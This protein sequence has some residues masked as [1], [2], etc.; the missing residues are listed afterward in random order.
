M[1]SEEGSLE[2]EGPSG[3][4]KVGSGSR[5]EIESKNMTPETLTQELRRFFGENLK[6]VVLYGSAARGEY[7]PRY[8]DYNLLVL[9]DHFDLPSFKKT[10]KVIRAWTKAGN[11]P[12]LLFTWD[13]LQRSQ[14]VFPIELL[15]MKEHHRV[16][17]GENPFKDVEIRSENLRLELE[18]ELKTNLIKLREHYLLTADKPKETQELLIKANSAF[19]VLFR[20][21]L[22]L[23]KISPL[24]NRKETPHVLSQ[25]I[26]I[27]SGVL[28]SIE[29]LKLGPSQT[30]K[31]G[32]DSVLEK[33]F[34]LVEQVIDAVDSHS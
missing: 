33:F 31:G 26:P 14:D 27:D 23:W 15:E 6:A 8:S 20:N 29:K 25:H 5:N 2:E 11:P 10:A 12:P 3:I 9:L 1:D 19:L 30:L 7:H 13:R 17:Y 22:R 21:V 24:P 34:K 4:G 28:N 16:L 32:L 18:R